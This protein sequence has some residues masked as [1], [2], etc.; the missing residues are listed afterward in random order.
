MLNSKDIFIRAPRVDAPS[1]N[2]LAKDTHTYLYKSYIHRWT[3]PLNEKQHGNN[4]VCVYYHLIYGDF[5]LHKKDQYTNSKQPALTEDL[6]HRA[7]LGGDMRLDSDSK[8]LASFS[9]SPLTANSLLLLT[10]SFL[11]LCLPSYCLSNEQLIKHLNLNHTR[12]GKKE[13][14]DMGTGF[15]FI[16]FCVF[17]L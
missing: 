8:L 3:C 7:A 1:V 12:P 13:K 2:A 17:F 4:S 9:L 10:L 5:V 14:D 11:D 6:G 16:L 15:Q